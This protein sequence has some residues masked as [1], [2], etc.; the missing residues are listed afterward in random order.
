MWYSCAGVLEE[1]GAFVLRTSGLNFRDRYLYIYIYDN[2]KII[3]QRTIVVD[4]S[5]EKR[6]LASSCPLVSPRLSARLFTGRICAK[7]GIGDFNE[8]P[9]S[10]SRCG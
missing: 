10:K 8:N 7:F 6:L 3:F 5:R 4:P 9:S 2:E 1:P